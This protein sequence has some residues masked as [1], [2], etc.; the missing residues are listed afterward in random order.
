MSLD[1]EW[2]SRLERWRLE[3]Q[4]RYYRPLDTVTLSGFLT[5]KQLA[6]DEAAKKKFRAMPPGTG[7]GK[8]WEYCWFR[9]AVR[10]PKEAK[11]RRIVLRPDLGGVEDTVYVNG[12][13]A[14]AR[15]LQH[16]EI[17]LCRRGV[18][19]TRYDILIESYAGHGKRYSD[20][21]PV[22]PGR[23]SVPE[24]VEPQVETG[25]STFGIW[26]EE[27]YQFSRDIE[28]LIGLRDAVDPASLR[29]AEVDEALRNFTLTVDL[30]VPYDEMMK[31]LRACRKNIAPLL[32]RRNGPTTPTFF[33]YGHA[34]LDVAWLWPL[35]ETERKAVRTFS[36]QLALME[37]YPEYRFLQS[38]P[39]LYRMIKNYRP[40]LYRRI[41]KAVRSGKI[42]PDGGMWV[43]SDTNVPCGESLIRQFVHG[44]RFF[45]DEFGVECNFLWLPDVFGYSGALPQI[46]RGCGLEYFS[47]AKIF[48]TYK[49]GDE[50]P[51]HTFTWEGIDGSQVLAHLIKGY[52]CPT[53][54]TAI[55]GFW[56]DRVQKDGISTMMFPFGHG[57]GGGGPTRHHLE[58]LR[59]QTDL[60]GL[61][62][63]RLGTPADFF[64]DLE[65]RGVPDVTHVGEIY[66]QAH[67]GTYTSQARTKRGNRLS[68]AALREAEMWGAL[69]RALGDYRYP[70]RKLDEAW[71]TVLLLQFHDIIPGSSIHRVYE[72]A[73]AAHASVIRTAGKAA[74][75]ARTSLTQ[76]AGRTLT[77][78][79]SLSWER[80][81]LVTLPDGFEG[82]ATTDGEQL[83]IQRVAGKTVAE[84]I[85]PPCGWTTLKAAPAARTANVLEAS[86]NLLENE[87]LRIRLNARGEIT[88]IFDKVARR[89]LAAGTCNQ[90]QMFKDVP[91]KC[92]A[93]DID[94]MYRDTPVPLRENATIRV[95]SRGPLV[96]ALK[97]TRRINNSKITQDIRLRRASSRVDFV[98]SVDWQES[99]KLLKAAFATDIRS[100][101]AIHEIQFGHLRRP[102][103]ESRPFD[104]DRYEVAQQKWTA[105]TEE[106]RGFAVMSDCK[107]GLS[108]TS[109]SISLTLLK[110]AVAPDMT[111]DRGHQE[112]T[113]S[114]YIWN[115][116]FAD[117]EIVKEAYDLSHPV[118]SAPG[119]A[120]TESVL[121]IDAPNVVIETIKPAEDGS[122][123]IVVRLYE[124]MRTATRCT[125]S[126]TLPVKRAA[127]TNML[128]EKAKRIPV[129]NGRVILDFRP[130]EVKTLRFKF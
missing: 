99:H 83:P 112:F 24:P 43:E 46:I 95:T 37:E 23:E 80:D 98:T 86:K 104:A 38:Q 59:R 122:G 75:A 87:C 126:T 100:D 49:G 107:Y 81:A 111:A 115:G 89:E 6:A 69:A 123:D 18:P 56:N 54:P 12:R 108:T 103:H 53:N 63:I 14:G 79:N 72:E 67:R 32:A 78:F 65:K 102:T 124:A 9:G 116:S 58:F 70:A 109:N 17:T 96:A 66:F 130:F 8:K 94:R 3:L 15:D 88:G 16:S 61:P 40:Q 45:R 30:E 85:V 7:W 34:H 118:T 110:S 22:A 50:F 97:V 47:T 73:E 128:E 33:A 60:E 91:S 113:Y 114:M 2:R 26:D 90:L 10:L 106:G 76:R 41:K 21:G 125:L 82:A 35:A 64:R 1:K 11:G 121:S 74:A 25:T 57:D 119:A 68:E 129:R 48:W 31:T 71:K 93:W 39:H 105:L 20:V 52:N 29:A 13:A 62:R 19:G 120:G 117:S 5:M 127:L 55:A 84:V 92:D 36:N 101:E 77:V 42:I 27:L 4:Q 51:H 28:T 44:I